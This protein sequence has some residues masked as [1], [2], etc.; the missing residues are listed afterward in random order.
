[1]VDIEALR[2]L[3]ALADTGSLTAAGRRLGVTQQAASARLRALEGD[4]GAVLVERSARGS[5]LTRVGELVEG[6]GRE[7]MAA[8]DRFDESVGALRERRRGALRVAA[9]LTVAEHLLPAWVAAWRERDPAAPGVRLDAENS[10]AVI[11]RVRRGGADLG[12]IETPDLPTD[13]RNVVIARDEIVIV[14][15]PSHP[16]AQRRRLDPAEVAGTALVLRER[17]SGTRRA[18]EAALDAAGT[19]LTAAPAAELPSSSAVRTTAAT[20]FAPAAVSALAVSDDLHSGRLV[21]VEMDGEVIT[22]PVAAVWA[23]REPEPAASRLL[24]VIADTLG[25]G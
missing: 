21:R 4:V 16:W 25:I 15:S 9:S 11:A 17:G 10:A 8:A 1:M 14:V 5:R 22:R 3:T 2:L 19:P 7:V 24:A 23:G 13:L 6:W 18:L 20:G 12:F